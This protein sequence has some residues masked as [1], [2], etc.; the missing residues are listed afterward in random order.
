MSTSCRV[1]QL[2]PDEVKDDNDYTSDL[3]CPV[4]VSIA[5]PVSK[6]ES[7]GE[8]VELEDGSYAY[9]PVEGQEPVL[10]EA[11]SLIQLIKAIDQCRDMGMLTLEDDDMGIL[12][13][14]AFAE[15]YR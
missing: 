2:H 12:F 7:F 15:V 1:V 6:D 13:S 8:I 10:I 14:R 4:R 5:F 11:P 9:L 3:S